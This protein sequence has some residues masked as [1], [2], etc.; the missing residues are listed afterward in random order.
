MNGYSCSEWVILKMATPKRTGS[1]EVKIIGITGIPLINPGDDLGEM[2]SEAA[3]RQGTPIMDGDVL[4]VT[5]KIVSKTEGRIYRLED[6]TPSYFARTV[7]RYSRKDPRLIELILRDSKAIVRNVGGHLITET[8][9]GWICANAGVDKSNVSG[10]DS[11]TLL[12]RD[13]DQSASRIRRRIEVLTNTTVAVIVSDTFGR[14]FRIGH[15]DV[16]IGSSGIDPVYDLR[17]TEDLFGY[18]LRVKRT[19]II[20][21]LASAAELVIGNAREKVPAAIVRGYAYPASEDA[22]ATN[23]VMP[24][25]TNLFP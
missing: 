10:G 23:L 5:Q 2:I 24:R 21:E 9:H 3:A 11:V 22:K 19:A 1:S 7:S 13:P 4:I 15:T 20:D 12:P 16:A 8:R 25:A 18:V 14:P 17:N 6:V